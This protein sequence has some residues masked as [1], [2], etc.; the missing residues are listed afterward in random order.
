[1]TGS[2]WDDLAIPPTADPAT[3]RRAY[4]MKLK[5]C[6]P[7]DDPEAFVRL[8][9]AYDAALRG[10][11]TA[12]VRR[13]S[14]L[15]MLLPPLHQTR[16]DQLSPPPATPLQQTEPTPEKLAAAAIVDGDV[17]SAATMLLAARGDTALPIGRWMWLTEQLAWRLAQDRRIEDPVVEAIARQFGWFGG[18]DHIATSAVKALR[19]RIEAARFLASV[20]AEAAKPTRYLGNERASACALLTGKGRLAASW[21]L[22][23]YVRLH[24]VL[25]GLQAHG[26]WAERRLDA[27]R[28]AR[29]RALDVDQRGQRIRRCAAAALVCALF[30]VTDQVFLAVLMPLLMLAIPLAWFRRLAVLAILFAVVAALA[31]LT[32]DLSVRY[33][34]PAAVAGLL[35]LYGCAT[36]TRIVRLLRRG[37]RETARSAGRFLLWLAMFGAILG[38]ID[39]V[40]LPHGLEGAFVG[41]ACF[42]LLSGAMRRRWRTWEKARPRNGAPRNGGHRQVAKPAR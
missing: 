39:V 16:L 7:D 14:E 42:V 4:A 21:L 38:V 19:V 35:A 17:H 10:T 24:E 22:P 28:V 18:P 31:G 33:G 41:I 20:R 32:G 1:V 2:I 36:V 6:R 27:D 37:P 40:F 15:P 34:V 12:P 29:L 26:M 23:P 30:A 25:S 9:A 11:A 8:R 5:Q 13:L 3:I